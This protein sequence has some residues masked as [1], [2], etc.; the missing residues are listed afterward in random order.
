MSQHTPNPGNPF[1]PNPPGPGE[2][3]SPVRDTPPWQWVPELVPSPGEARVHKRFNSAFEDTE[4][5]ASL[6]VLQYVHEA[7]GRGI[8]YDRAASSAD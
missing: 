6:D 2:V 1:Q 8:P 5:L 4:L 7:M 3:P